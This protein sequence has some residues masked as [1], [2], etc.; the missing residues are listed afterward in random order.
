ML[1]FK[2]YNMKTYLI[3]IISMLFSIQV[4]AQDYQFFDS[5]S[6]VIDDEYVLNEDLIKEAAK[7]VHYNVDDMFTYKHANGY[8]TTGDHDRMSIVVYDAD[9]N[10]YQ[11]RMY[12]YEDMYP[13][14]LRKEY[15]KLEPIVT[16]A[17]KR[18][19]NGELDEFY[20]TKVQNSSSVW[21]EITFF[22]MIED[23]IFQR[24]VILN[25]DLVQVEVFDEQYN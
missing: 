11:T 17:V 20:L 21:Y 24:Y 8:I 1:N 14:K 22:V 4:L 13:K 19:N 25:E 10:W 2:I 7:L 15:Y 16:E 6:E 9:E 3:V 5:Y 12:Y 18:N 23:E